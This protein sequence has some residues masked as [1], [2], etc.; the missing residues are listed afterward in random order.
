MPPIYEAKLTSA[1]EGFT[2]PCFRISSD[3]LNTKARAP[4]SVTKL[5]LSGGTHEGVEV[6]EVDN[7]AMV[8]RVSPTRGMGI[9]DVRSGEDRF[10]W[11]SPVKEVVHPA[12]LDL[13]ARG[14]LG[15]LAGFNEWMCRCGLESN[16]MPGEDTFVDGS[17]NERKVFLTLHGRIANVPA[18]EASVSVLLE[19][20]YTITLK[21]TVAESSMFM[22]NFVLETALS[23]VP[24]ETTFTLTDVVQNARGVTEE[25]QMLYHTNFGV[26]LLEK[27]ARFVAAIRK[28]APRDARAAETMKTF[29]LYGTPEA[30]YVEAVYFMKLQA[31]RRGETRVLLKDARGTR[32]SSISFSVKELP[33]FTVWKNTSALADGYVTGL[34][35]ATNFPNMRRFERTKRRTVRMRPGMRYRMSLEFA[36]HRGKDEVAQVEKYIR[37]LTKR[38]PIICKE[39][40]PEFSAVGQK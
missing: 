3:D 36:L 13:E 31:D 1:K 7:G 6:V 27:G 4:W 24:G 20:P 21:G 23:V 34:E 35:P 9:L 5:T 16:G 28:I 17:G 38:P 37:T 32:G 40:D 10:G 26:P 8:I 14:G 30:G 33:C 22:P 15:W 25:M 11:D 12:L 19:K 2:L 18:S 39:P 29:D